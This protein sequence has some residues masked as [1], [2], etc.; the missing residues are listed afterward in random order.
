MAALFHFLSR[1]GGGCACLEG[2]KE[3]PEPSLLVRSQ[4]HGMGVSAEG[5]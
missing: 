3:A 5:C 1:R 4:V 2:R